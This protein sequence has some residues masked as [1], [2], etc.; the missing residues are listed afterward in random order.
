MNDVKT[1]ILWS[2]TQTK[3]LN[4]YKKIANIIKNLDRI[5]LDK[6]KD[7]FEQISPGLFH[8]Y[9][10]LRNDNSMAVYACSLSPNSYFSRFEDLQILIELWRNGEKWE[11]ISLRLYGN[12][13]YSYHIQQHAEIS[14]LYSKIDFDV[15]ED[16]SFSLNSTGF[17]SY[18]NSMLKMNFEDAI[19]YA[20]KLIKFSFLIAPKLAMLLMQRRKFNL[21]N[22][23]K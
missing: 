11:D 5:E 6:V 2:H 13:K 3:T 12:T 22:L 8:L 9:D 7:S 18:A 4:C 10:W 20:L 17:S 21:N 1:R 16:F 15:A 23:K 14:G 19:T